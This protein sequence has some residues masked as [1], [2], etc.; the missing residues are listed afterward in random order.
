MH[1]NFTETNIYVMAIIFLFNVM[2]VRKNEIDTKY[3]GGLTQFRSD[4]MKRPRR[5]REDEHLLACS[6][7]GFDFKDA[8]E[9]L[10]ALGVELLVT[11]E[12]VPPEENVKLCSW[13]AWDIYERI[14]IKSP[15]G[16]VQIHEVP[17]HWLKGTEP[18]ETSDFRPPK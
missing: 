3:P 17:R 18:G 8:G 11:D 9:R 2:V 6:S 14:E 12:S 1:T 13:L 15:G 16:F 7:M 5:W 4:W 10:R